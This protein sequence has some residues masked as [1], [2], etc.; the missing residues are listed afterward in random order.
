MKNIY[1]TL[2][3]RVSEMLLAQSPF[4][5]KASLVPLK[6]RLRNCNLYLKEGYIKLFFITYP[7]F[8]T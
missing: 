6:V 3:P 1:L 8:L 7:F 5:F 2:L 4:S